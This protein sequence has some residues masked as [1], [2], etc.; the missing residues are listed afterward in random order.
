MPDNEQRNFPDETIRRFLLGNLNR[1]ERSLFEQ[2]LFADDVLEERV[3]LT[4]LELADDYASGR[5]SHPEQITFRERFL[6]TT[7]R[8]TKLQ[9]SKAIH[10]NF[11]TSAAL[12]HGDGV[13][14][15]IM[16][17]FDF[18]RHVWKYAFATLILVLLLATALLVKK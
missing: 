8:Q 15:R 1:A 5:L 7:D 9:V 17:A 12:M 10:T 3:R 16:N 13:F 4:E 14:Q 18:R 2:S 11:A 6:L